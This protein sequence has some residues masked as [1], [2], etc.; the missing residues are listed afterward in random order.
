MTTER[1]H[2]N[3]NAALLTREEHCYEIAFREIEENTR[4][5]A[6]W[7]EAF[8]R[9]MGDEQKAKALYIK[10]R[11]KQL[12]REQP[13]KR[14]RSAAEAI[15]EAWPPITSGQVFRCP[16]CGAR[17]TARY[18]FWISSTLHHYICRVCGA[19]LR[20]ASD[21]PLP[22][23]NPWA[24]WGFIIGLISVFFHWIGVIPIAAI[25]LSAMGLA[26]FD[27]KTQKNQWMAGVGL[28]LGIVF[29][30][31]YMRQFGHI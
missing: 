27:P 11:V 26:T 23:N 14:A 4:S 31:V 21:L 28:G 22:S 1:L 6:I 30:L 3:S 16:Y 10:L 12:V 18:D 8:S 25:V 20:V 2:D 7:A 24:V 19:E 17:T 9:A 5:V 13:R 15:R 29:G